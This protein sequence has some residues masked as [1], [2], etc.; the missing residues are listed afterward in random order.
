MKKF[1]L[2][3]L[4]S[5]PFL[6]LKYTGGKCNVPS[7]RF[8]RQYKNELNKHILMSTLNLIVFLD[9]AKQ[10]HVI[11]STLL[12]LRRSSVKS[13]RALLNVICRDY[14]SGIGNLFKHLFQLQINVSYEQSPLEELEFFVSN[15]A[16][17]L[18]DGSRLGKLAELLSNRH[19]ILEEMRL[20][21]ISRLQKVHN[22]SVALR[23]LSQVGIPNVS[24]IHPNYIVDG[25]RPQVLK[26]LWSIISSC[27]LENVIRK[28]KLRDEIYNIHSAN[29]HRKDPYNFSKHCGN[30]ETCNDVCQ[31]LLIWCDSIC[32][33][34][35]YEITDFSRSFYDGVAP[36]L[37][38]AYYH[39]SIV[40]FKSI[41]PT[42]N[43]KRES[44]KASEKVMAIRNE[45]QNCH[46]SQEKMHSLGGIPNMFP[47]SDMDNLPDERSVIVCIAYLCARLL[48]SSEE[49]NAIIIIQTSFRKHLAARLER[50]KRGAVIT[51]ERF[52][53][54][55]KK[56]YFSVQRDLYSIPIKKIESF[57]C[58][59]RPKLKVMQRRRQ[60]CV[61]IQVR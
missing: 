26:M 31:L 28:D 7:G 42:S 47:I 15:L 53:L 23:H 25:H 5:D 59:H 55:N 2:D 11:E 16:T 40:N 20:P 51:I 56:K 38:I 24:A 30:I 29:V 17:D 48:E 8:E 13:S 41:L 50:I 52:W 18:R 39:P 1:I 3:R 45:H 36:L 49:L 35:G 21:A 61:K 54:Q 4:L 22:V 33:T 27:Q 6:K 9:A 58:S 37:L 12:F 34:F 44:L 32:R 43:Y 60:C 46:L 57:L 10:Q 14:I 19:N